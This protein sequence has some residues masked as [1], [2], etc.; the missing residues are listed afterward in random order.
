M[1]SMISS[2]D[3]MRKPS[4]VTNSTVG[5]GMRALLD[6]VLQIRASVRHTVSRWFNS[7][8]KRPNRGLGPLHEAAMNRRPPW[9]SDCPSP[10][11]AADNR[12]RQTIVPGTDP[13]D[14][15]WKKDSG[16]VQPGTG[17][18]ERGP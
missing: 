18:D 15:N 8:T 2:Q 9:A 17:L 16:L 13:A 1:V 14:T 11:P 7:F 4:W 12:P 5:L 6:R 3:R 10:T